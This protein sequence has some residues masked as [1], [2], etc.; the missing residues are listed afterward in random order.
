MF[1]FCGLCVCLCVCVCLVAAFS[2][3][4]CPKKHLKHVEENISKTRECSSKCQS[5]QQSGT[6]YESNFAD[7]K[8]TGKFTPAEFMNSQ[9]AKFRNI[10]AVVFK[11]SES[12][13]QNSVY[14]YFYTSCLHIYIYMFDS[15]KKITNYDY[16]SL[17]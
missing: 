17:Q 1:V 2:F 14:L 16:P 12:P 8:Q 3:L 11:H 15:F 9:V 7:G 5:G 10:F 6:W 4:I 13:Y